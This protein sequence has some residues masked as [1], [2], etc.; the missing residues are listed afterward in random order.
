MTVDLS[1]PLLTSHRGGK[2]LLSCNPPPHFSSPFSCCPCC[3]SFVRTSVS[4]IVIKQM[5]T[6]EVLWLHFLTNLLYPRANNTCFLKMCSISYVSLAKF[7]AHIPRA[8]NVWNN[9]LSP[10][11]SPEASL[12]RSWASSFFSSFS[13]AGG[14]RGVLGPASPSFQR[15][16]CWPASVFLLLA[17][18]SHFTAAHLPMTER[19]ASKPSSPCLCEVL[20]A[21]RVT[22]SAVC[23]IR[24]R[25]SLSSECRRQCSAVLWPLRLVLTCLIPSRFTFLHFRVTRQIIYCHPWDPGGAS[26]RRGWQASAITGLARGL[27]LAARLGPSLLA[28]PQFTMRWLMQGS[29]PFMA[30]GCRGFLPVIPFGEVFVMI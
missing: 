11:L 21:A 9:V 3:H 14:W 27:F 22:P 4:N 6:S 28:E 16:T 10:P 30:L 26:G 7:P 24:G 18:C 1:N 23:G 12:R 13:P 25:R 15:E 20:C 5:L 2:D 8:L 17:M 19:V 29:F